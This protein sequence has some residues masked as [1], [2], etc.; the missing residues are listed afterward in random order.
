VISAE[1]SRRN[2][3]LAGHLIQQEIRWLILHGLL[4]LLEYDHETDQG[5]MTKLELSLRGRLG[6]GG[7]GGKGKSK[8]KAKSKRPKPRQA[9]DGRRYTAYGLSRG[10]R[11][12]YPRLYTICS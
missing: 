8:N 11:P 12:V 4:H 9:V 5:E 7:P 6:I 1:T 3:A 10:R 2:A